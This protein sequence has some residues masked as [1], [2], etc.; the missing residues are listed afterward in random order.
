MDT[1]GTKGGTVRVDFLRIPPCISA[2]C[3]YIGGIATEDDMKNTFVGT[4]TVRYIDNDNYR[5]I[6]FEENPRGM[7]TLQADI[8]A[9]KTRN[10]TA[11]AICGLQANGWRV[12]ETR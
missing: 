11:S 12:T 1:T 2:Q 8:E 10:V 5:V 3:A 4:A 7:G 6:F 9:L